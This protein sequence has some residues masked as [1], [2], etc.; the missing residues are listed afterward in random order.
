MGPHGIKWCSHTWFLRPVGKLTLPELQ[1]Y[2]QYSETRLGHQAPLAEMYASL[3]ASVSARA[4]GA[5][6]ADFEEFVDLV[7]AQVAVMGGTKEWIKTQ[8][9]AWGGVE[10]RSWG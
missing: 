4:P 8:V 2:I 7:R 3:A 9:R 10:G 5:Q 1:T 6:Q